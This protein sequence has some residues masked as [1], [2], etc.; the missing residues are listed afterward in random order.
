MASSRFSWL[1]RWAALFALV[2]FAGD[3]AADSIADL[4]GDHC[5]AQT[6][7]AASHNQQGECSHCSCATHSGTVLVT[8]S[9]VPL[10]GELYST[11]LF[12]SRAATRVPK[13]AVA[14]DHPPQLA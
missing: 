5:V 1:A 14:I 9:S 12:S 6:S 3:I 11:Q 4:R 8:D 2:L 7:E 10:T 13:L